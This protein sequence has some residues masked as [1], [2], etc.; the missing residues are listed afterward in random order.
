LQ[1]GRPQCSPCAS[2]RGG[3]ATS[4]R[5]LAE[6][7]HD[8]SVQTLAVANQELLD[9]RR[10]RRDESFRRASVAIAEVLRKLRGEITELYPYV[11]DHAGLE[12]ALRALVG[13]V[14][15]GMAAEVE[16]EVDP[17][18]AGTHDELLVA[19]AR[20]LLTNAARHSSA[21]RAPRRSPA[22]ATATPQLPWSC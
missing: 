3:A 15:E 21:T 17:G 9:Y 18:A 10:T 8:E 19:L 6:V 20:E 5:R 7:L 13:R 12:P 22:C 1:S 16:V 11:L 14:A 2:P 4:A